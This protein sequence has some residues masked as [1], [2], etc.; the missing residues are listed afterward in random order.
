ME[1]FMESQYTL[2]QHFFFCHCNQRRGGWQWRSELG[3]VCLKARA[4]PPRFKAKR[5]S[6]CPRCYRQWKSSWWADN[7]G[8]RWLPGSVSWPQEPTPGSS[9]PGLVASPCSP[10]WPERRA[11]WPHLHYRACTLLPHKC[12]EPT[13]G[14]VKTMLFTATAAT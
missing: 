10:H 11:S 9:S 13:L 12:A 14:L 4:C 3:F 5:C 8:L 7:P 2:K 1:V 6:W